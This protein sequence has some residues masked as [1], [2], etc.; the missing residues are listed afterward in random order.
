MDDTVVIVAAF[1]YW[2]A[3]MATVRRCP[4]AGLT[5]RHTMSRTARRANEH[6]SRELL[7]F[8][9]THQ[10]GVP[11]AERLPSSLSSVVFVGILYAPNR[12]AFSFQKSHM[13][14]VQAVTVSK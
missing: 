4:L 9:V 7:E 3:C 6:T 5:A 10:G 14:H 12:R 8:N 2:F 1:R 11:I 13:G